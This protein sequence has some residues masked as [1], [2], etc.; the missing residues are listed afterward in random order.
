MTLHEFESQVPKKILDRG[1][2]YY[3]QDCIRRVEQ[4]DALEFS[5]NIRGSEWY[6]VFIKLNNKHEITQ[7]Y[8][9]CPYDYGDVCKHIVA[10]LYYI[11]DSGMYAEPHNNFTAKATKIIATLSEAEIRDFLLDSLKESRKLR[12][13]FRLAFK[14]KD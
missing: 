11:R 8:C 6:E 2:D 9:S 13:L 5:A 7:H 10:T 12:K 14:K 4:I 1:F 3:E